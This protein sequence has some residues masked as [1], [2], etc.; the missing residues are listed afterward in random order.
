M[1][2]A[3]KTSIINYDITVKDQRRNYKSSV[4]LPSLENVELIK[5]NMKSQESIWGP[6]QQRKL[7]YKITPKCVQVKDPKDNSKEDKPSSVSSHVPP[8]S[9]SVIE[10]MR[11]V[12]QSIAGKASSD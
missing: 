12:S 5:S 9:P 2:K 8:L 4:I 7:K 3:N 1:Q 6:G 10:K 11:N